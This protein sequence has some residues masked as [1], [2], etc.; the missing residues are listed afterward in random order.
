MGT[1]HSAQEVMGIQTPHLPSLLQV[2]NQ[3][4][5]SWYETRNSIDQNTV[6]R[7]DSIVN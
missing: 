1:S 5:V 6:R 2:C 3:A 4:F 7:K